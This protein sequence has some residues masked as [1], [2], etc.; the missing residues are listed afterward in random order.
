M[1]ETFKNILRWTLFLVIIASIFYLMV[2]IKPEY[3]NYEVRGAD[4]T[5]YHTTRVHYGTSDVWFTDDNGN[6][7]VL[8]GGYTVIE[9]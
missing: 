7:V 9:K 8:G 4:G 2:Q 6:R 1:N 3:R 5:I